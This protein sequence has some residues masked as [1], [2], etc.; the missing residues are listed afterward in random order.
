MSGFRFS[1]EVTRRSFSNT[2][3]C[4]HQLAC[5]SFRNGCG[6]WVAISV[7]QLRRCPNLR[8]QLRRHS[9]CRNRD[10]NAPSEQTER[11]KKE[12]PAPGESTWEPQHDRNCGGNEAQPHKDTDNTF[13]QARRFFLSAAAA[14]L[15]GPA[16]LVTHGRSL[17]RRY[18]ALRT[19][20][21]T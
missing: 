3:R 2:W 21:K 8:R 18:S 12:S 10:R 1:T 14:A 19:W 15:A 6:N 17:H 13:F 5:I 16:L 7:C 11:G 4:R 9:R 20:D